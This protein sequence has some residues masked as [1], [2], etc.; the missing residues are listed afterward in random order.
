MSFSLYDAVVPT[1][2]QT[3]GA[4]DALL[5]KAEA[6][7]AEHGRAEAELIDARLAPDMLPFGYQVKSCVTHSVGAVEGVKAGSFSPDLAA[8]PTDF[9]GL[10]AKLQGAI[11]DLNSIDRDAFDALGDNDTLFSFGE[12][13]LPFT[14]AN[15]LLSFSQPNFFFHAATAYAILRAQGVKVGKGDFLGRP[16]LKPAA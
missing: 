10:H 3:L 16:R 11:A 12:M 1:N 7:C 6:F 5:V 13:R 8:W 2:L 14:G 4:I 9:A 15:F